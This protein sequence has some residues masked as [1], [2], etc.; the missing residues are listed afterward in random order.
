MTILMPTLCILKLTLRSIPHYKTYILSSR[1]CVSSNSHLNK[2]IQ[3]VICEMV[4]GGM[5]FFFFFKSIN[6]IYYEACYYIWQLLN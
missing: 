1:S 3:D 6:H 2:Q 5:F 4:R